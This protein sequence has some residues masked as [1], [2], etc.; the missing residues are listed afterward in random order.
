MVKTCYPLPL[1]HWLRIFIS[2][3]GLL[4]KFL[5]ETDVTKLF[6]TYLDKMV[7]CKVWFLRLLLS[8]CLLRFWLVVKPSAFFVQFQ[9]R[10]WL[11]ICSIDQIQTIS[12]WLDL[13][14]GENILSNW[15]RLENVNVYGIVTGIKLFVKSSYQQQNSSVVSSERK[16]ESQIF[17]AQWNEWKKEIVLG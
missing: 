3:Q 12:N 4:Q 17:W 2:K 5:L 9:S 8:T 11:N 13:N 15:S 14:W 7:V 16:E 6:I 10:N 1:M